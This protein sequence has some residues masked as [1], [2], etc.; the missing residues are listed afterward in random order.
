MSSRPATPAAPRRSTS[1]TPPARPKRALVSSFKPG[2]T[3]EGVAANGASEEVYVSRSAT[4]N[5]EVY[6]ATKVIPDVVTEAPVLQH[7]RAAPPSPARSTPTGSN[8]TNASSNG[9]T[10]AGSTHYT[11]TTPCAE[12]PAEIGA[13]TTPVAVHADISGLIPQGTQYHYRLVAANPNATIEGSNQ[14]FTTPDT[15]TT[16][17]ATGLTDDRGDP[18]RDSQPRRRNARRMRLRMGTAKKPRR[19]SPAVSQQR[20]LCTGSRGDHRHQSGRG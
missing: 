3:A 6:G 11:E 8:W 13:G 5:V 14:N 9:A 4:E 20:A 17:A 12:T 19:T 16:E 7:R 10:P 1:T 15:V 18:A 2:S